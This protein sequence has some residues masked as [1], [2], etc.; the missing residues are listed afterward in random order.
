MDNELLAFEHALRAHVNAAIAK[1]DAFD[2]RM[3]EYNASWHIQYDGADG[4]SWRV[5]P[6]YRYRI[7]ATIRAAALDDALRIAFNACEAAAGARILPS[8]ITHDSESSNV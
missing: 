1:C 6:P 7:S 8:L 3:C 4:G 5:E 2:E